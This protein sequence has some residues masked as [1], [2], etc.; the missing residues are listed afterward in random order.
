M[1]WEKSYGGSGLEVITGLVEDIA[2]NIMIGG[3]SDSPIGGTKT[4]PKIGDYDYWL[5][6][7][8]KQ[9][10][11]KWQQ[12]YGGSGKD[13]L[14]VLIPTKDGGYLVGGDSNSD[15]GGMKT[16]ENFGFNDYWFFKLECGWDFEPNYSFVG[17]EGTPLLLDLESEECPNCVFTWP[18]ESVG[19]QFLYTEN[20]PFGE[21]FSVGVSTSDGCPL[22]KEVMVTFKQA[23]TF[24]LGNDTTVYKNTHVV[25]RPNPAL[26]TGT[27]NWSNGDTTL[28]TLASESGTYGL[29]IEID[30]CVIYEE[31]RIDFEGNRNVYIPSA[32]S[33]NN[34]GFNDVFRIYA[35]EAIKSIKQ[36]LIF[37]RWGNQVFELND[38]KPGFN[39][40]GWNGTFNGKVIKEGV[41]IYFIEVA[42]TDGTSELIKGDITLLR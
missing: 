23:P 31:I 7:I 22:T 32:F 19:S 36:F 14:T 3:L 26:L 35:D 38:F 39:S 27:F 30:G 33:P 2:G 24:S 40:D 28:T 13:A 25:L 21:T 17:C 6:F 10:V 11:E 37:D 42:Y 5:I 15:E 20:R 34:D 41:F 9:G 12:T 1:V 18:D 29:T 4:A 16:T 8:D